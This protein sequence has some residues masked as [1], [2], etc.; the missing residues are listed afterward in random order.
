MNLDKLEKQVFR[1]RYRDGL[2]E[3]Y[4]GM[5]MLSMGLIP[6]LEHWGVSRFIGYI[7]FIGLPM[8]AFLFVERRA[9]KPRL[10]YVQFSPARR[11]KLALI[12]FWIALGVTLTFGLMILTIGGQFPGRVGEVWEGWLIPLFLC[13]LIL[14]IFTVL[15][16]YLENPRFY[17]IGLLFGISLG[18]SEIL[19]N[20]WSAPWRE[21]TLFGLSGGMVLVMGLVSF[22]R[23]LKETD[24]VAG[25][26]TIGDGINDH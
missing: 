26:F 2:R 10:G 3:L 7:L 6:L 11:K 19:R 1:S 13:S 15:A 25:E 12:P 16:W 24:E 21:L 5:V 22:R 23:F 4:I 20:L 8:V 9:V 14:A 17:L 18:L